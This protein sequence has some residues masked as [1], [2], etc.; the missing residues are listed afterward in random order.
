M[1]GKYLQLADG[2]LIE[3]L[4][5]DGYSGAGAAG[6]LVALNAD[7]RLAADLLAG[8]MIGRNLLH[9]GAFA[10][11]QR[12]SF[13]NVTVNPNTT[14]L[15]IDR[16]RGGVSDSAGVLTYSKPFASVAGQLRRRSLRATVTTP[17]ASNFVGSTGYVAPFWQQIDPGIFLALYNETLSLRFDFLSNVAGRFAVA[18]INGQLTHA[19]RYS[20]VATFDYAVA[21]V[22]Q[23]VQK[24]LQCNPPVWGSAVTQTSLFIGAVNY[25]QDVTGS[26]QVGRATSPETCNQWNHWDAMTALDCTNWTTTAGNYVEVA[27]VQLER[28][29]APTAFDR[30]DFAWELLRVQRYFE[31]VNSRL[32]FVAAAAG[33]VFR[34]RQVFAVPKNG[35]PGMTNT[36]QTLTNVAAVA[37]E[38]A[39]LNGFDFMVQATAA[40][41]VDAAVTWTADTGY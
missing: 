39:G 28:S 22:R 38:N 37:A 24:T 19:N 6:K 14:P 23:S 4:A 2:Q 10:Q 32:S 11:D 29:P 35:P 27:D 9:N 7:G 8:Q 12:F 18:L 5:V 40:G 16:W 3:V 30:V 34:M 36:A 33:D 17:P 20:Y 41:P 15:V 26:P 25:T 13:A 1:T 31:V 21:G